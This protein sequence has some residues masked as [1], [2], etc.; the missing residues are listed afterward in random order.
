LTE[1]GPRPEF[2]D[3]YGA[4]ETDSPDYPPRTRANVE[5]SDGTLWLGSIDSRGFRVT[6]DAALRRLPSY[7]F[8]IVYQGQTPPSEVVT[9]IGANKIRVLNVAG[10]RESVNPGIGERSERFLLAVFRQLARG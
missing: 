6:H 5:A 3:L 1:A 7:P 9:W 2:R 10:Y 8:L 4:I